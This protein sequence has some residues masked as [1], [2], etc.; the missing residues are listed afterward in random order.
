MTLV[1]AT[2]LL[3]TGCQSSPTPAASASQSAAAK[4]SD[5][6]SSAP[7]ASAGPTATPTPV[8][9]TCDQVLTTEQLAAMLPVLVPASDYQPAKGSDAAKAVSY[10]GVACGY[11]NP[12]SGNTV[13]VSIAQPASGELTGLKNDAIT[14]S[15]VVPTYGVP[16]KVMGY[17]SVDHGSGVAQAFTGKYWVVASSKD[18][19]EPGDAGPVI[20]GVLANL[21][22]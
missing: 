21:P 22:G 16:P 1:A 10:S 3:L 5:A 9:L 4:A 20:A 2:A 8:A 7:K 13:S 19:T 18:F 12:S 17:F 6:P 14:Q 11:A 15:N